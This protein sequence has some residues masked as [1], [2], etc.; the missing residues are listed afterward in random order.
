MIMMINNY[1]I[2]Y[3]MNMFKQLNDVSDMGII[4]IKINN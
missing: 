1:T 4:M 2:H 3:F